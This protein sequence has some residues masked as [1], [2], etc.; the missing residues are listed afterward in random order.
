MKSINRSIAALAA[1]LLISAC[2]GSDGGGAPLEPVG[3]VGAGLGTDTDQGSGA[4]VV[5]GTDA[6]DGTQN[7]DSG[8]PVGSN[9]TDAGEDT[10]PIIDA[11]TPL[12]LGPLP[13]TPSTEAPSADDEPIPQAS[14]LNTITR[15]QVVRE[16]APRVPFKF[17]EI[18]FTEEDFAAGLPEAVVTVP[19]DVDPATNLPPFFEGLDNVRVNA[20]DIVEI[21][22]IPRDPEGELPGMFAQE[23]P[24]GATFDDNFDGTRT[25]L[26]QTFQADIGITD[27]TVV[28]IDPANGLYRSSQTLLIAVDESVDGSTEP[29]IAPTIEPVTSYTVRVG[30]PAVILLDGF[31]R[32]GTTPS[33]E[34]LNPP[35]TATLTPDERDPDLQWLQVIPDE[36]GTLT[37]DVLTRD[38]LDPNLTGLDQITLF[39]RP[40]SDFD[41]AGARLKDA[42]TGSG[43]LFGSAVS[44]VF[45]LQGD[46][47]VYESF[48]ASEFGIMTPESSMKWDA[49]NPLPGAYT[50]ADMDNLMRFAEV[51]DMSVR[52]HPLVWHRSLPTWVEATAAADRE[53]HMR[54]FIT[55]VMDRYSDGIDY[56]DVVNEPLN[57]ADGNMRQ[58]IWFEA[59]GE[60]Y[61]DIAFL[62]ARE[63]DPNATLVL[64]EF[65][66]GFA[67]PKFDGLVELIDRL[68]E[69]SVPVDAIGFQMHVFSS[70]DQFD[71][72]SANMAAMAERGLDIHVTE[73]DVAIVDGGDA[74]QQAAV[75][76]GVIDVCQAQPR[77]SVLQTWGFTDRYSFRTFLDPLY[78]DRSYQVKESYGAMQDALGTN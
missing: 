38:E 13:A 20:G 60:S 24:E 23:L 33:I 10:V 17:P 15:F 12:V 72:L 40:V 52:G 58:S 67:G 32:N 30:D 53:V 41:R 29:N 11:G 28:A 16:P 7:P 6:V 74:A 5:D 3:S 76:A 4:E 39:V 57:D 71:E 2:S 48:A 69:R 21:R 54:E 70:Y 46:G 62:Q 50:F 36:V 51:N 25:L 73:L 55:R 14:E 43:V 22:Y 1:L 26:W 37:I 35:T 42:S 56:W 78:L 75:Y 59:M 45:Y 31:D 8:V 64:N 63:L 44:P 77:C 66:I 47:G 65:D 19:A 9:E 49:M 68:Q 34:L 27:F 61:I 18:E